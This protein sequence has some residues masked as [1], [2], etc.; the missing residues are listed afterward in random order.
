MAASSPKDTPNNVHSSTT[1]N[2]K[3]ETTHMPSNRMGMLPK[4]STAQ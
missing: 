4:L 2:H 3:L 1:F